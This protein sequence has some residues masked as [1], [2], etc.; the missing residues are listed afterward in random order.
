MI[1]YVSRMFSFGF[2]QKGA[3]LRMLNE[4]SNGMILYN[5]GRYENALNQFERCISIYDN[6]KQ[7]NMREYFITK[8]KIALCL[9]KMGNYDKSEKVLID[10]IKS[11]KKKSKIDSFYLSNLIALTSYYDI[12]KSEYYI[13]NII[14][15]K[16]NINKEDRVKFLIEASSIKYSNNKEKEAKNIIE[17]I[18]SNDS[19]FKAMILHNKGIINECKEDLIKAITVLDKAKISKEDFIKAKSL[20]LVELCNILINNNE[21]NHPSKLWWKTTLNHFNDNQTNL[22]SNSLLFNK[23]ISLLGTLYSDLSQTLISE[24]LFQKSIDF[25][26]ITKEIDTLYNNPPLLNSIKFFTYNQY[27]NSLISQEKRSLEGNQLLNKASTFN[28]KEW[29]NKLSQLHYLNI[30]I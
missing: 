15:N 11:T 24:G 30:N 27:G 3:T 10:I 4:F 9:Y 26:F 12:N 17:S 25:S 28:V 2:V 19:L 5:K 22:I 16:Y 6:V 8:Q 20:S 18:Q 13:D 29:Y 1:K 21:A 14:H 23:F 7:C